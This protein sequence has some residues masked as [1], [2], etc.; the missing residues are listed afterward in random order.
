MSM[1]STKDTLNHKHNVRSMSAGSL[2]SV[3]SSDRANHQKTS[4]KNTFKI[5]E[6]KK[7]NYKDYLS[8]NIDLDLNSNYSI[9][10][11]LNTNPHLP[12]NNNNIEKK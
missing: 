3:R 4:I 9:N 6:K 8:S 7:S 2:L 1:M 12:I 11:N 5:I 10:I